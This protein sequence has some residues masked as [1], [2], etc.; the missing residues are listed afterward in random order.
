MILTMGLCRFLDNK[1]TVVFG[2]CF[3]FL[4]QAFLSRLCPSIA[5]K[6]LDRVEHCFARRS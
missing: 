4:T 3:L 2:H 6:R 5:F 1:K